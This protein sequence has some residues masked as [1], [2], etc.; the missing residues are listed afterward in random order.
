M[1]LIEKNT[2]PHLAD[3]VRSDNY[4]TNR[5][6][7]DYANPHHPQTTALFIE[8]LKELRSQDIFLD[9]GVGQGQML[10]EF[11]MSRLILLEDPTDVYFREVPESQRDEIHWDEPL[12]YFPQKSLLD[13]GPLDQRAHMVGISLRPPRRGFTKSFKALL[14]TKRAQYFQM[15]LKQYAQ[16]HPG[17][18]KLLTDNYGANHYGPFDEFLLSAWTVLRD[19]GQSFFANSIVILNEKGERITINDYINDYCSGLEIF[20]EPT[21]RSWELNGIRKNKESFCLTPLS[22]LPTQGRD[23]YNVTYQV[24]SPSCR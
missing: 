18:V 14:A 3:K 24:Q 4:T 20:T 5:K 13:L 19:D 22:I 6:I 8:A 10:G 2:I 15:S 1:K 23:V 9:S 12:T 7:Y 11:G 21:K 16:E 17:S